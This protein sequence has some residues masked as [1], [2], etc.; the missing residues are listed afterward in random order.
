MWGNMALA[1]SK[2][3]PGISWRVFASSR[4]CVVVSCEISLLP[5]GE[6]AP[7]VNSSESV[8]ERAVTFANMTAV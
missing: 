6:M 7:V 5:I 2:V 8:K 3:S 1:V 4:M